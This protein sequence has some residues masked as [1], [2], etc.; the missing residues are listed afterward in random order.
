MLAVGE[1][2]GLTQAAGLG[3]FVVATQR[4]LV[5]DVRHLVLVSIL[6]VVVELVT[7]TVV[8]SS[9]SHSTALLLVAGI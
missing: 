9:F 6:L 8:L 7:V 4:R 1:G 2:A 3:Q 5:L